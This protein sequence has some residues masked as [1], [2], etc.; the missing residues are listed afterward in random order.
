[1]ARK[2]KAP[3]KVL[4]EFERLEDELLTFNSLCSINSGLPAFGQ[5]DAS[6]AALLRKIETYRPLSQWERL[7]LGERYNQAICTANQLGGTQDVEVPRTV[8]PI[9]IEVEGG[10]VTDV[11]GL[12]P[13]Q[14]WVL[15]D[16]DNEETDGD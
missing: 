1:M 16:H 8:P 6:R 15:I 13:G 11:R 5:L 3:A 9:V 14:T 4:T 2:I 7:N 12:L 10:V